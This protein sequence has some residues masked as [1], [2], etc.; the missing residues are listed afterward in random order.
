[1]K[2]NLILSIFS[3]LLFCTKIFAQGEVYTWGNIP[4]ADLIATQCPIEPEANA[5]ILFDVADVSLDIPNSNWKVIQKRHKRIKIY[6]EKGLDN[7]N[8]SI[9]YYSYKNIAEIYGIE[10][11]SIA[12]DGTITKLN[13][14]EIFTERLNEYRSVVKF[15][16]PNVVPGS[17]IEFRYNLITE[18]ITQLIDWYFQADIP[19]QLSRLIFEKPV[20]FEY[21]YV[22]YGDN[23]FKT[24]KVA[25]IANDKEYTNTFINNV[26]I[27][28]FTH[29]NLPAFKDDSFTT[30]KDDYISRLAFQLRSISYT[31]I[32]T[33]T[34]FT[35][36]ETT[37]KD[38]L[39]NSGV[40]KIINSKATKRFLKKAPHLA[41]G[42][43]EEEKMLNAFN[44]VKNGVVWNDYYGI[45]AD[46]NITQLLDS[47]TGNIAEINYNLVSLL[48]QI[49]LKAFPILTSTR[50]H[51]KCLKD[52]PIIEQFN[53]VV[54]GV[55]ID[56]EV[57][58]LDASNQYNTPNL[59]DLNALNKVGW[60]FSETD[61]GWLPMKM[62]QSRLHKQETINLDE[63]KG[64]NVD[65][66]SYSQGYFT[67]RQSQKID[68]GN[69]NIRFENDYG[70]QVTIENYE[71]DKEQIKDGKLKETVQLSNA[72]TLKT[73]GNLM[74][75]D[76]TLD[77]FFQENPFKAKTRNHP[78]DFHFPKVYTIISD[79]TIPQG[80]EIESIPESLHL[81]LGEGKVLKYRFVAVKNPKIVKLERSFAINQ[82]VIS[83]KNYEIVKQYFEQIVQ[84]EQEQLI[85]KKIK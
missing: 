58:F 63:K 44:F 33:V 41:K 51:G 4:E 62:Q 35:S 18:N 26:N 25:S 61:E 50:N 56:D 5:M 79:F 30:T 32:N 3:L 29:Q 2:K 7:T 75:V 42:N 84:K 20:F 16:I 24:K 77:K 45:S 6:N 72:G 60:F 64:I 65:V 54:A 82:P 31:N 74:Y 22:T 46:K 38:L 80:W 27:I 47:K 1:M 67:V 83:A 8:I 53:Y 13:K 52:Y 14:K 40:G 66:V 49:G 81:D 70:N 37:K 43:T 15:A 85:L 69:E 76:F 39:D 48:K 17:V 9:P 21:V 59:I 73:R 36:W 71:F 78:I 10:A 11:Q 55:K 34:Y 28:T 23:S 19:T 57:Y 68:S 12:P